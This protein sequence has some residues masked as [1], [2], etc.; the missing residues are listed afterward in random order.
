LLALAG[1]AAD[2]PGFRGPGGQGVSTEHGLPVRWSTTAGVRW[3]AELPGRGLSSPVV[4]GGRVYVTACS[5]YRDRCLHV[6]CLDASTGAKRWERRFT[7][8]GNT[9]CNPSTNMAAP[10]PA[11][12]AHG[13][14]A[15]FASGDLAALDPD[16]NLLWYRSLVGDYP[17][18]TNQVG[19]AASPVL[20][21]DV[22]LL[23]MIN[24]GDSF[25]VGL[26]RHTGKNRWRLRRRSDLA[27]AT[28]ILLPAENA[29]IALFQTPTHAIAVDTK[30]GKI[31]WEFADEKLSPIKSPCAGEVL[32]FLAAD[33]MV[34]VRPTSDGSTPKE[35]WRSGNV[36]AGYAS[37]LF[38]AGRVYYLTPVALVGLDAT[39]GREIGRQRVDGPFDASPVIANGKLYATNNRGRTTVLEL[40]DRPKVLARNDLGEAI[41]TTPAL[42]GGCIYFRSEKALYCVGPKK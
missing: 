26:D 36:S 21:G 15:L 16:G 42:A 17:N 10:T 2:W 18:V 4:V 40:G 12:D 28:P 30:T 27:W 25:L 39:T 6:L 13:V 34:A 5:G 37:P 23:P 32:V 24:V 35:I 7:A 31:A 41:Q 3:K 20:A 11:A 1:L 33:G 14:C 29:Q 8:S 38:H 22:L 19:M 9:T